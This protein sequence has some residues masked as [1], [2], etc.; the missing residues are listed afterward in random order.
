MLPPVMNTYLDENKAR[1]QQLD[2]QQTQDFINLLAAHD[3]TAI[4]KWH[5]LQADFHRHLPLDVFVQLKD[6]VERF[7]LEQACQILTQYTDNDLI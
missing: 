2:K 5:E 4:Y 1:S 3:G 7:D 6:S